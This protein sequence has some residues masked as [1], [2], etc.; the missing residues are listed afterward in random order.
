M[1]GGGSLLAF[2]DV[3]AFYGHA[4]ILHGVSFEVGSGESVAILGRNGVGKTTVINTLLGIARKGSGN[5]VFQGVAQASLR[6]YQAARL[7][8]GVVLQG[9]YIFPNLTVR[10]N[11]LL[12]AA[13]ARPGQW[14]LKTVFELFPILRERAASLGTML[15]GGQQ[16]MLAI[17]RALM[18]NPNLLVL[19]EPSEGLAPV[20]VDELAEVLLRLRSEGT[21]L[22]L[23]EQNLSLIERVSRRFAVLSKGRIVEQA[24]LEGIDVLSL[25]HHITI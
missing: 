2:D 20:I 9:R 14:T 5:V 4:H 18:A 15:S 16:Q 17:G 10:E 23:V 13:S 11:L 6:N 8:I 21:A 24:S 1:T 25:R 19:D 22:L 3:H 12:G 7:G